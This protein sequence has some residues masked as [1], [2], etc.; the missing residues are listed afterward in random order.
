MRLLVQRCWSVTSRNTT[1][2]LGVH[3]L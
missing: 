3:V 2:W 1:D